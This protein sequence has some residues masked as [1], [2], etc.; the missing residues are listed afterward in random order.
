LQCSGW[1]L[2]FKSAFRVR[3]ELRREQMDQVMYGRPVVVRCAVCFISIGFLTNASSAGFLDSFCGNSRAANPVGS[4]LLSGNFA[5]LDRF[6]GTSSPGDVFG[7]GLAEFDNVATLGLGSAAFDTNARYLYLYQ[8]VNSPMSTII[9]LG[10]TYG[11]GKDR[12]ST[13]TSYAHWGLFL[14]D[15]N[16]ILSTSNDFG[17]DGVPFMPAAL[18]NIGVIAPSVSSD[19][20]AGEL[21]AVALDPS[22]T[23]FT[24]LGGLPQGSINRLHGYTTNQPPEFIYEPI[25][26]GF[27]TWSYPVPQVVPVPSTL[28]LVLL[29]TPTG[30]SAAT[31]RRRRD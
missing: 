29:A 11:D 25:I 18:P 19:P 7:T 28:L 27:A 13:I 15:N 8:T 31:R 22:P 5:V 6:S 20:S 14:S 3:I 9:G 10:G 4:L 23:L 24:V 1:I 21:F 26:P 2:L 16:G 17:I 12:F 30:L